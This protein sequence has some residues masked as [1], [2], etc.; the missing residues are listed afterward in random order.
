[1]VLTGDVI[2]VCPD[3]WTYVGYS[4]P[5]EC[6]DLVEDVVSWRMFFPGHAMLDMLI[7]Y[8]G[9]GAVEGRDLVNFG[10]RLDPKKGHLSHTGAANAY[11]IRGHA[12]EK[13]RFSVGNYEWYA[14]VSFCALV[15]FFLVESFAGGLRVLHSD[16]VMTDVVGGRNF[17]GLGN[18]AGVFGIR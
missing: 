11:Y 7:A 2:S 14:A 15:V 18:V 1:M 8:V 9:R 10:V 5:R 3:F 6:S 17:T 12:P 13:A 16:G 4:T